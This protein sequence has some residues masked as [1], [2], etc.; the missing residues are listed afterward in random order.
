M[1]KVYP[2]ASNIIPQVDL[3]FE[4]GRGDFHAPVGQASSLLPSKNPQSL[5]G[6]KIPQ[7]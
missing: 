7:A 3:G 4:K 5:N 2:V 1:I 6:F